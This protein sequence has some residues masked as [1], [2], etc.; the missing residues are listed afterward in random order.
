MTHM[1]TP[2][3]TPAEMLAEAKTIE[4]GTHP[5]FGPGTPAMIRRLAAKALRDRAEAAK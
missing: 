4:D 5:F 2:I 3:A 1:S